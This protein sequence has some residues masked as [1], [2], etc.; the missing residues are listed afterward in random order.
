[1]AG[2]TLVRSRS[3]RQRVY[4]II[5]RDGAVLATVLAASVAEVVA[6]PEASAAPLES[7]IMLADGA[8]V[9]ARRELWAG[10]YPGWSVAAG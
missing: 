8:R 6:T 1:M 3:A 9:L 4:R 5:S 2:R 10:E 7:R